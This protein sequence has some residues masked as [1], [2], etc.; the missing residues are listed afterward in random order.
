[1]HKRLILIF[2]IYL[3]L[4]KPVSHAQQ[5]LNF[6]GNFPIFENNIE[7]V[8]EFEEKEFLLLLQ[9]TKAIIWNGTL[10]IFDETKE[11]FQMPEIEIDS[12]EFFRE[13]AALKIGDRI[14]QVS[15]NE[16]DNAQ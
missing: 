4:S 16:P 14:L 2:F 8:D 7:F 11:D 10:I 1:M 3:L 6:Q 15:S 12:Q 13:V 5:Q 9:D